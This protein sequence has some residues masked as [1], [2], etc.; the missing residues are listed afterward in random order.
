MDNNITAGCLEFHA[1]MQ[2]L[3]ERIEIIIGY[4]QNAHILIL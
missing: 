1:R 3:P 2:K 4:K